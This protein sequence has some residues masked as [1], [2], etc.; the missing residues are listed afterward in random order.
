MKPI[1]LM[2]VDDHELIRIALTFAFE[3]EA[4]IELVGVFGSAEDALEA[5]PDARPDVT[6]M[7]VLM[8]GMDGIEACRLLRSASPDTRVV[9]LTSS[10]E[11]RAVTASIMA[12]ASGYLLKN[13]SKSELSR[14]V[15]LAARG[16][17]LMDQAQVLR[18]L[19]SAISPALDDRSQSPNALSDREKQILALVAEGMT[20]REIAAA[21]VISPNTVR[22]H[23]SRILFKLGLT[24]RGQAARFIARRN[25]ATGDEPPPN[26]RRRR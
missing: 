17:S 4:D 26:T 3:F 6:L 12:G 1:R 14:A 15:R 24:R 18:A 20:N 25:P 5:A 16:E 23:V 2:I 10:S 19:E 9:M 13:L 22:N 7:D 21:L 8:P 11:S